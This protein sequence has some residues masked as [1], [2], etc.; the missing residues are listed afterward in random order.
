[1]DRADTFPRWKRFFTWPWLMALFAVL[2]TLAIC[3]RHYDPFYIERIWPQIGMPLTIAFAALAISKAELRRHPGTR[4]MALYFLWYLAVLILNRW[5]LAY[6]F[7]DFR[8]VLYRLLFTTLVCFPLGIALGHRRRLA[9]AVFSAFTAAFALLGA[10]G[11][12]CVLAQTHWYTPYH[13]GALGLGFEASTG[14]R[15]YLFAHPNIS[16]AALMMALL[17][18]LYLCLTG[19]GLISRLWHGLCCLPMFV[20]LGLTVSRTSMLA[21]AAAIGILAFLAV[22]RWRLPRRRW[23]V[24]GASLV[25]AALAAAL[26][27]A[28]LHLVNTVALRLITANAS[29][30]EIAQAQTSAAAPLDSPVEYFPSDNADSSADDTDTT[31][32]DTVPA[33][34]DAVPAADNAETSA[35][36]LRFPTDNLDGQLTVPVQ[37]ELSGT[38]MRTIASRLRIWTRALNVVAE[39]PR[40]LLRG[41]TLERLMLVIDY[42]PP[43]RFVHLHNSYLTVLLSMGVI[44]FAL[45]LCF[46]WGLGRASLRR[47]FSRDASVGLGE[48]FLPAIFVAC[49]LIG[50]LE[51][52]YFTGQYFM[53]RLFY[54]L[55]GF[56]M[57]REA[58]ARA[59]D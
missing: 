48:R 32:D 50:F 22:Q 7:A 3:T 42:P 19:R 25:G 39:N 29:V 40:I 28:S 8:L 2:E 24:W 23:I 58:A 45:M 1:M 30:E 46:L 34:D 56:V 10:I 44:G 14:L 51:P 37:R 57:A 5:F 38:D 4:W 41:T 49:L 31:T 27:F 20:A 54:I 59:K 26:C 15:L 33:T 52:F 13:H 21:T 35:P 12:Y 16:G 43:E 55:A 9:R 17:L 47:M 6:E 36:A 53:D 11:I 18:S